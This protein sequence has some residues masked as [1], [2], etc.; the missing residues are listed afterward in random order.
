MRICVPSSTLLLW[1]SDGGA[2]T[3][4]IQLVASRE[5]RSKER[6]LLQVALPPSVHCASPSRP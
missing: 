6:N 1:R 5:G 3:V 4:Q 2:R